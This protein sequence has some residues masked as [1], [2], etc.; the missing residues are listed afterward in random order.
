MQDLTCKGTK[1]YLLVIDDAGV[2][3]VLQ[4]DVR[5]LFVRVP[6][7][8]ELDGGLDGGGV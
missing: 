5:L 8:G 2:I 3:G 6:I 1:G 4:G 7:D